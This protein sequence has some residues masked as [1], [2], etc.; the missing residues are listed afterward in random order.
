MTTKIKTPQPEKLTLGT[1]NSSGSGMSETKLIVNQLID[2]VAE[3]REEVEKNNP[4]TQ[5]YA[6]QPSTHVHT[7]SLKE[8]LLQ[9]ITNA[10]DF[11]WRNDCRYINI[12]EV[13]AII[14][15]HLK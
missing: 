3:L 9:E 2:V 14:N 1:G 5:A 11:V 12:E 15:R 6:D 8:T 7:P 4:L 10:D 13:E